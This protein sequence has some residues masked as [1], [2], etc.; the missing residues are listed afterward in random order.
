MHQLGSSHG[1]GSSRDCL[2][3]RIL[4]R[5]VTGAVIRAIIRTIIRSVV[6]AFIGP[7]R[8]VVAIKALRVVVVLVSTFQAR[9]AG[10]RAI[11]TLTA[12]W[13]KMMTSARRPRRGE[14]GISMG[15]TYIVPNG[16]AEQQPQWPTR[17][18]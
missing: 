9:L 5:V 2:L 10:R 8:V 14:E 11:P 6:L 7:G 1:R 16:L 13:V 18:R 12:T 17:R 3:I 4:T 15:T